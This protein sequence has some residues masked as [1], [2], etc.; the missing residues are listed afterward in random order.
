MEPKDEE[1]ERLRMRQ[2]TNNCLLHNSQ[3]S[4]T[5]QSIRPWSTTV[6]TGTRILTTAAYWSFI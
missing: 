2:L 5:S 6:A 3:A 4:F 1:V